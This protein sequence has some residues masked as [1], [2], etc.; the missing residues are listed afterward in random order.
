M[1]NQYAVAWVSTSSLDQDEIISTWV[2]TWNEIFRIFTDEQLRLAPGETRNA[3]FTKEI[4]KHLRDA[5]NKKILVYKSDKVNGFCIIQDKK[6]FIQIY[7]IAV[8]PYT[9]LNLRAVALA[10]SKQLQTDYPTSEFRGMVKTINERGKMLYRYLGVVE[11]DDWHDEEYDR[12][13]IPLKITS[14]AA[15]LASENNA[16]TPMPPELMPSDT[17]HNVSK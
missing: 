14:T 9:L 3:H 13:H 6:E 12:H 7:G 15:K 1:G 10:L 16:T 17:S 11:C 5:L 4:K 8:K 2:S